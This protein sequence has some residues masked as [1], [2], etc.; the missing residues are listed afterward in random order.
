MQLTRIGQFTLQWGES[1]VW[2]ERSERLYFVDCFANTIHWIEHGSE[3]LH[4]MPVPSMPTGLV[5]TEA[6]G[7]VVVLD[8]GFYLVDPDRGTVA[9]LTPFPTEIGGRCNDLCADL[10]GNL[11]TGKLNLGPAEGSA[12]WYSPVHGWRLLDPDI[13]NTNGPAV[14]VLDGAMTLIVGDTSTHYYAYPYNPS[15]GWVGSRRIFGDVTD[16]AGGPDGSTMDRDG[17]LWRP[18]RQFHDKRSQPA[19]G[20]AGQEPDGRDL[21]RSRPRRSLRRIDGWR[22]RA[23]WQFA[24]HRRPRRRWPCRAALAVGLIDSWTTGAA[25]LPAVGNAFSRSRR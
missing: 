13:S 8:D 18:G 17:G 24:P 9:L 1:L 3:D 10:D 19:G 12:W 20:P 14:T 21:R 5:P 15:T 23:R 6:G 22:R 2:D 25:S 11:I 16:L 7:L 4:G